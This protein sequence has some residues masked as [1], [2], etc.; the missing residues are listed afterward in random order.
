M[1]YNGSTAV[2]LEN[3]LTIKTNPTQM[4]PEHELYV[5][6]TVGYTFN[7]SSLTITTTDINT[8]DTCTAFL[9]SWEEEG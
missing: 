3:E 5:I 7:H 1:Y 4:L 6:Y 2:Y 8:G 9:K